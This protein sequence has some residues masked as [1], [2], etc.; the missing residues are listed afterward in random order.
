MP[1]EEITIEDLVNWYCEEHNIVLWKDVEGFPGYEVS[2]VGGEVRN[3]QTGRILKL[4]KGSRGYHF[5]QLYNNGVSKNCLVHRLVA[6]SWV[7]NPQKHQQ[8]NHIDERKTSNNAANLEWVDA[9]FNDNWGTRNRRIAKS[10]LKPVLQYSKTGTLLR[11]WSSLMEAEQSLN[12][13]IC[14][15]S[16]CCRGKRQSAGGYVWKYA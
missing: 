16:S 2:N 9:S 1:T 15:I 10:K 13:S 14:H 3:K 6:E 5:V 11:E 7:P 4:L 8:V 12:V